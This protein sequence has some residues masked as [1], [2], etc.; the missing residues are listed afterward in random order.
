MR[1]NTG[2]ACLPVSSLL[3]ITGRIGIIAA[4]RTR[5]IR[6]RVGSRSVCGGANGAGIHRATESAAAGDAGERHRRERAADDV[7]EEGGPTIRAGDISLEGL[8]VECQL[9]SFKLRIFQHDD[10]VLY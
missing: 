3:S 10:G 1:L 6:C 4:G 8:N 2:S 5:I 7:D 9:V